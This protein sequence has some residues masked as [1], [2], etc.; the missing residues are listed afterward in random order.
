MCI[1]SDYWR[2]G[3]RGALR[4][5][6]P[7]NERLRHFCLRN[8]LDLWTRE[9]IARLLTILAVKCGLPVSIWHISVSILHLHH[10]LHH[11]HNIERPYSTN[12]LA[13]RKIS[14]S[15]RLF[16]ESQFYD[17]SRIFAGCIP[18]PND[19]PPD[20]GSF[21]MKIQL[22]SMMLPTLPSFTSTPSL[23]WVEFVRT[24]TFWKM[25]E[26]YDIGEQCVASSSPWI[27]CLDSI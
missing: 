27:D 24:V 26:L 14:M 11:T 12:M 17:T 1:Q 9:T 22:F 7:L 2:R 15:N 21:C 3:I 18:K 16:G 10:Q 20:L 8:G 13:T 19:A 4:A 23:L 6:R 5:P 25:G